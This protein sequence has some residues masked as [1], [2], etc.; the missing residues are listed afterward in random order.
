MDEALCGLPRRWFPAI[1]AIKVQ[2][3]PVENPI[4]LLPKFG[5]KEQDTIF[6]CAAVRSMR[7][8]IH[9]IVA[10]VW[11]PYMAMS[12]KGRRWPPGH[13]E[14]LFIPSPTQITLTDNVI[15]DW[16]SPLTSCCSRT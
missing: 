16:M 1:E 15:I 9:F 6:W 2:K 3:F 8:L 7:R 11:W 14:Y 4:T 13:Q 5:N 12:P 10:S